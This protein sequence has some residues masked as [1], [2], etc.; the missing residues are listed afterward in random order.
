M[1]HAPMAPTFR[2]EAHGMT[3]VGEKRQYNEDH[4]GCFPE[5]GLFLVADGMGGHS[6]GDRASKLV[7]A[8]ARR[9]RTW[10]TAGSTGSAAESWS[11][12]RGIT[13]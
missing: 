9:S 10:G 12:S 2:I 11:R 7:V 13:R 5:L 8:A 6:S 3:D 4:F 1:H